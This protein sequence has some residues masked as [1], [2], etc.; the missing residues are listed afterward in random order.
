VVFNFLKKPEVSNSETKGAE[1]PKGVAELLRF[2]VERLVD[3]PGDIQIKEVEGAKTTVLELRVNDAD[4]GKVIGKKGRI[5]KSLRVVLRAAA[6]HEGRSISVELMSDGERN[7]D[8][9]AD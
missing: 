9:T 5:I 4:M 1:A 7:V 2:V 6:L 8:G 3:N